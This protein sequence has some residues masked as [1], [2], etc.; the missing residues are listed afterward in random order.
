[1]TKPRKFIVSHR[2]NGLG[3]SVMNHGVSYSKS[4]DR[5]Y[6][7][8]IELS[9]IAEL[10]EKLAIAVEALSKIVEVSGTS[11]EHWHMANKALAKIKGEK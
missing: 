6:Y 1:M 2:K 7:H 10:E 11:T 5:V 4:E 9:S 3:L 8:V